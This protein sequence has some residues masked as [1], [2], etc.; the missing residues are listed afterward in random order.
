MYT[1]WYTN[2]IKSDLVYLYNN[3]ESSNT[4]TNNAWGKEIIDYLHKNNI[5]V[6]AMLQLPTYEKQHWNEGKIGSGI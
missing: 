3:Q 6:G 5:S 1:K 4:K 2:G